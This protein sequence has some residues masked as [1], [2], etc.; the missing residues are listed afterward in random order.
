MKYNI[1]E[2]NL[3]MNPSRTLW[4]GNLDKN[5]TDDKLKEIFNKISKY[6][7]K[8]KFLFRCENIKFKII[9]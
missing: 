5:I 7:K 2:I 6:T 8:L 1:L 3:N 9:F 4:M